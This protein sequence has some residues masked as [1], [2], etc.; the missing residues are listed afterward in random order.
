[1]TLVIVFI[2]LAAINASLKSHD[3]LFDT[4]EKVK[5]MK[6]SNTNELSWKPSEEQMETLKFVIGNHIFGH[7]E[8]Q[9][10]LKSL[11]ND[12]KKL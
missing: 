1:M 8:H 4:I 12:L 3:K 10:I 2:M 6:T 5:Q 7:Q 9:G 11:Y